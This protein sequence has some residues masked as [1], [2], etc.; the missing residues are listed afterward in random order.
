MPIYEYTCDDCRTEFELLIRGQEKPVCPSCGRS[1]L[2]RSLSVTAAHVAG[3]KEPGC[4]AQASCGMKR[5]PSDG[6]GM[7][8]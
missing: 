8:S 4:P 7:F 3:S 2:T 1:R 6:C 5:C